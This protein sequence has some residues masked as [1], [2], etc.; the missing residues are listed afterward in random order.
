MMLD[1][2]RRELW[3]REGERRVIYSFR[4]IHD[5]DGYSSP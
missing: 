2:G 4:E 5:L 1:I 3:V